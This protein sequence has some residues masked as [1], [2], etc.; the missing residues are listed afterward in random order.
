[1]G[2]VLAF[3]RARAENVAAAMLAAMFL[4]FLVQI[5]GRYV[6]AEP[7]GWTL[8]LC[9]MLWVW[10]VFWGCAFIVREQ[11]HVTFDLL[12]QMA[13]RRI[14]R[15][16]ALVSAGAIV[17]GFVVAF[18]P[19][20]DYVDFLK[21]KRSATLRLPLRSVFSIYVLFMASVIVAYAIRFVVI[22]RKGPPPREEAGPA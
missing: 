21:I 17:V 10:L 8:E 18:W 16:F 5:F 4:T 2:A 13:P 1:M 11:D 6:L 12:Y 20:W 22:W 15:V 7:F 19:T 3:L 14:Q 9:L